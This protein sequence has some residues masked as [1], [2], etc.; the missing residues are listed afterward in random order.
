M[1]S[2][3]LLG[4]KALAARFVVAAATLFGFSTTAFAQDRALEGVWAVTSTPRDCT[5][6]AT[7][8]PPIRALMTFHEGGT[9]TE[10]A[11]LLLFAPGQRSLGHGVWTPAGGSTFRERTLTLILFDAGPF[12]AGWTLTTHNI[13]LSDANNFT[14]TGTTGFYDTNRQFLRE[15]CASRAGQRFR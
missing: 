7:L 15:V 2:M 5:T 10:S 8:G 13:I 12:Q 4:G 3:I 6:G 11:A 14:S 1:D 9:I